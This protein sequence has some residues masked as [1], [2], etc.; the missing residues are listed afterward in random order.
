MAPSKKHPAY[1]SAAIGLTVTCAFFLLLE[2]V[3]R[4]T[5]LP[6]RI[7]A[8]SASP[9]YVE[10]PAWMLR[11]A[12]TRERAARMSVN[13]AVIDWLSIFEEGEGFRVRLVP[14]MSKHIFN[15]FGLTKADRE[16][17]YLVESNSLGFRGPEIRF[18]KPPNTFRIAIFGDS[19][20]FGWGVNYEDSYAG[21]LQNEL[22]KLAPSRAIEIANFSI[23]GDSSEYGRLIFERY[24]PQL[25]ADF[26]IFGF[27]ANDAKR[28]SVPHQPQ[29]NAFRETSKRL[30]LRRSLERSALFKTL[31]R[32]LDSVIS[33]NGPNHSMQKSAPV[34][35][36]PK[37]RFRENIAAFI[38]ES[39]RMGSST[40][41][42]VLSLCTPGD[43]AK[44]AQKTARR[45]NALY[46]NGQAELIKALPQIQSGKIYPELAQDIRNQI[47]SE[48]L[49][50]TDLLYIT[51]DGCH[52]NRLGHRLIGAELAQLIFK[53]VPNFQN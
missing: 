11:D 5:N 52:P 49:K 28:V 10:M 34:A 27:G 9:S 19:S 12:N 15:T 35:A 30:A 14:N 53:E 41:A 32:A 40:K 13:A 43:Y 4:V 51:S 24:A 47:R 48:D 7:S 45:N 42:L 39:S 18:P 16:T 36:V 50:R 3:A 26:F 25:G 22:S 23:P 17:P 37:S 6:Q 2:I 20:S 31:S 29:V 1:Y 46:L 21:V 38:N 8:K 44:A 33:G